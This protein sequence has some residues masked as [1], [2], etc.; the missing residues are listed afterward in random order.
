MKAIRRNI[1]ETRKNE[2]PHHFFGNP[3]RASFFKP[4]QRANSDTIRR[5]LIKDNQE[6][7]AGQEVPSIVSQALSSGGDPLDK[8]S[9]TSMEQKFGH[10]FSQ[11]KIHTGELAAQSAFSINAL[12]YTS[13]NNIVFNDGQYNPGSANGKKLLA[14]ELTHVVQQR[15]GGAV[16]RMIQCEMVRDRDGALVFRTREQ[17]QT[18]LENMIRIVPD[19]DHADQFLIEWRWDPTSPATD[20]WIRGT[21]SRS[22]EAAERRMSELMRIAGE[23]GRWYV[24]KDTDLRPQTRAR[25]PRAE[26]GGGEERSTARGRVCLTF[27]DGPQNGTE[28]VLNELRSFGIH[29]TFFLT[30]RN[31]T[32]NPTQLAEQA[33]LVR[34][35]LDEGH[36]IGNHTFTHDVASRAQYRSAYG[37]LIDDDRPDSTAEATSFRSDLSSNESHFR[38]QLGENFPGF[39]IAR[40]PGDGRFFARLRERV[41]RMGMRHISWQFEFAKNGDFGH[42]RFHDWQRISNAA[43]SHEGLPRAG[44]VILFHDRHWGGGHQT[45][46]HAIIDKLRTAGFSF[47]VI[48]REG[49]CADG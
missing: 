12:A 10:D 13:G 42:L 48:N 36:R 27:D 20:Q 30:G 38:T 31:M 28:A 24:E 3:K 14:H 11:V 26:S 43:A 6:E 25:A 23:E 18:R 33:R 44:N 2:S 41:E 21:R 1:P 29:G 35:M 37:T 45:T 9:R 34:R 7:K 47:G 16:A 49:D 32:G 4:K 5:E 19:P 15:A 40:L 8:D 46:L 22:R 39:D 17:A